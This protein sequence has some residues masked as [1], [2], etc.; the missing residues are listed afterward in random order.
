MSE[1][2]ESGGQGGR[3]SKD[4][5]GEF[6]GPLC[7]CCCWYSV[8][9][10]AALALFMLVMMV[11]VAVVMAVVRVGEEEVVSSSSSLRLYSQLPHCHCRILHP[12]FS[13]PFSSYCALKS[14]VVLLKQRRQKSHTTACHINVYIFAHRHVKKGTDLVAACLPSLIV[15]FLMFSASVALRTRIICF[16]YLLRLEPVLMETSG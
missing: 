6:G 12:A 13:T 7:C 11:G 5:N 8:I 14:C 3:G 16:Y 4:G 9:I 15:D 10:V 2:G 1:R